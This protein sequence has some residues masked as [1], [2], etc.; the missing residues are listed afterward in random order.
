MKQK[1]YIIINISLI[2]LYNIFMIFIVILPV[3]EKY[4]NFRITGN[5]MDIIIIISSTGQIRTVFPLIIYINTLLNYSL[6][7]ILTKFITGMVC[8]P[9]IIIIFMVAKMARLEPKDRVGPKIFSPK[10]SYGPKKMSRKKYVK[11]C[12]SKISTN[13]NPDLVYL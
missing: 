2:T 5:P 11:Y 10:D 9:K 8:Q 12:T 1:K 13:P 4:G 6:I 7:G 3:Y